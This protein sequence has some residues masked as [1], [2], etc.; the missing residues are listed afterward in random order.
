MR[1]LVLT[2]LAAL[3]LAAPVD[4]RPRGAATSGAVV[5]ASG[6]TINATWPSGSASASTLACGTGYGS[7]TINAAD[8]GTQTSTT[9]H[10]GILSGLTPGTRYYCQAKSGAAVT[11]EFPL[12]TESN[13]PST[14]VVS[15]AFG[16]A[17]QPVSNQIASDT[18]DN[19]VSNDGTTYITNDDANPAWAG[20]GSTAMGIGKFTSESPLTGAN[21]NLMSDYGAQNAIGSDSATGKLSGLYCLGG[22]IYGMMARQDRSSAS[23]TN[24]IYSQTAGNILKSANHGTTWTNFQGTTN[25]NGA[26]TSPINAGFFGT[27]ASGSFVAAAGNSIFAAASFVMYGVDD[28]TL[29]YRVD[30]ADAYVYAVSNDAYWDNGN[31]LYLARVLRAKLPNLSGAD[32]QYFTGGDGL[33]DANWS[34][35]YSLASAVITST[36][37]IGYTAVQYLPKLNRYLAWTWFYPG[38]P[39]T[40][41]AFSQTSHW[42]VYESAHPWGPWTAVT[43]TG[44]TSN[45]NATTCRWNPSGWYNPA[46]WVKSVTT[47]KP[48]DAGNPLHLWVAG[49]YF[50][51]AATYYRFYDMPVT[52][53]TH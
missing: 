34:G 30:N 28:G 52:V 36:G 49:D 14:P 19:C 38:A 10:S 20:T 15:L 46:P 17:T 7:Y 53:N 21:V 16:T 42:V 29:G 40:G 27:T 4:A 23:T 6:T 24:H 39:A 9:S 18:F 32:W 48:D 26:I 37:K 22:N 51:G 41:S 8:A 50:D 2:A 3:A 31:A 11:A 45:P 5:S 1:R 35:N 47:M 25:A 44:C 43:V 12:Y 33:Q 13:P